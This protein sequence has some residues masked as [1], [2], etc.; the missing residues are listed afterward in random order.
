MT[1]Q[2]ER[3]QNPFAARIIAWSIHFFTA[4]AAVLGLYTLFAIHLGNYQ[5]AFWLMAIT[6]VIDSVDGTLARRFKVKHWVPQID[7]ALLDNMVDYLNYVITPAFFLTV[8]DLLPTG[9]KLLVA[10]VVVLT[11]AYQFTQSDAKTSDHFFK[12]FPSYWNLAVF[13]LFLAHLKPW[14]NAGILLFLAIMIF[15]PI[16]YLYL[17]RLE[18]ITRN[19]SLLRGLKI[20]ISIYALATFGLLIIYPKTNLFLIT[21]SWLFAILYIYL[22]F[23]RTLK[24]LP[25]Y[26]E[27]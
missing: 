16:K 2:F 24:P 19:M 25:V 9:W 23:Y 5:L 4:S 14:L 18:N 21:I 22:S 13:Y 15:V 10:G 8:S 26:Q 3:P 17:S 11:S 1:S 12:G 27:D 7:G 20:A 6:I